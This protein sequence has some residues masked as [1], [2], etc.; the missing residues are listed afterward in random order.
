MDNSHRHT[1]NRSTFLKR[2]FQLS[3]LAALTPLAGPLSSRPLPGSGAAAA[4]G[5]DDIMRRLMTENDSQTRRL[6]DAG[7]ISLG[8]QIG[9]DFAV[10]SAAYSSPASVFHHDPRVSDALEARARELL[11]EQNPDGTMNFSNLGSPPD[12]AFLVTPLAVGMTVLGREASP[13]LAGVSKLMKQ[14][15][16]KAGGALAVGGVH[17][18]NHRWVV[19][20]ALARLNALYPDMNYLARINDWLGEGIFNDDDGHFLERSR[21]YSRVEDSTIITLARLLNKPA[22]LDPVR[23]N[24]RMTYY[25][26]EPDGS[27]VVNDSRR[28]DQYETVSI[29]LYYLSYRYMAIR[30]GSGEFAAITRFM[31]QMKGFGDVV[32]KQSLCF[33][34]EDPLLV[35]PLP[36]SGVLAT[37]FEKLF[38]TSNLLRIRRAQTTTTLFGGIDWPIN[39][40]S[41]RSNSP[42][43][44]AFRK[45]DAVLKYLRLST[46]FF[47]MGYFYSD[48]IKKE[49]ESYVLYKKEEV[50]YYQPLPPGLRRADGDYKLSPSV[51]SRFWNCMDYSERPVSNV[52][53]LETKVTFGEKNGRNELI[54]S[55]TGSDKIT[56]VIELCFREGGVLSG[57]TQGA[58]GHNFLVGQ[59]ATY[60]YGK[61]SIRFG[62]GGGAP[63]VIEDLAGERYSNHFGNLHTPGMHVYITGTTPFQHTLRFE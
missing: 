55:L 52:K 47:S 19:S 1:L 33:F 13:A 12:T 53:T 36:P 34:M 15:L 27:L 16:V 26:M 30:D 54:F 5:D 18:P 59:Q 63:V 41:G 61:D 6:L 20:S 3:A 22:L 9:Y 39:I 11:E 7:A 35:K 32:L 46:N 25:Y 23:K 28:Q 56:V 2:S 48:G 24:L 51:D 44:Y 40:I 58:D 31:E 62:P 37:N 4:P 38:S 49:G 17:T 42:D 57:V 50:P 45:N 43:F 14:F 29:L 21:N 8:R 60:S 10:L